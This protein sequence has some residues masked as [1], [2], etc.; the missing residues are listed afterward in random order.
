MQTKLIRAGFKKAATQESLEVAATLW[1]SFLPG[2][3]NFDMKQLCR[4]EPVGE[5][6]IL[7][8]MLECTKS[9]QFDSGDL[10]FFNIHYQ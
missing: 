6:L 9:A 2:A 10:K 3:E 7:K 4:P 8:K 5:D 1:A